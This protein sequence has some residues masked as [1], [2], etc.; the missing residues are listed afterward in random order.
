MS[1][2]RKHIIAALRWFALVCATLTTWVA[3]THAD[4]G[5]RVSNIA[6]ISQETANGTLVIST[7]DASF[8]I[9]A[10]RTPS[11]VEFFRVVDTAPDAISVRLNGS[12]FSPSGALSGPFSSFEDVVLLQQKPLNTSDPV[13]LVPAETYLPGE[14]MVVRVV[15]VGQNG[16]EDTIE[17]VVIRVTADNGDRLTLRLYEDTPNSGHFYGFFPSSPNQTA[18]N[19]RTLTAPQDALLTATYVDAFDASEVS[20]DTALVDPFGSVFD[21]YTGELIDNIRVS[22]VNADTGL[23]AEVLGIDG[24]GAYPAE[25]QTGESVTDTNRITYPAS[26]GTFFF[27]IVAPGRYRLSVDAPEGYVFPSSRSASEIQDL[28]SGP[29]ELRTDASFGDVFEV[30]STGPLN[31]DL[32]IDPAGDLTIRKRASDPQA[33]IG[34]FV[35]YTITLENT[36]TVPAPFALQDNLPTGLRYV[37]G[38]ARVNGQPFNDPQISGDGLG[39]LFEGGLVL[40]AST[41]QLT[42]LT[43]VGPGTPQ[44]EAVNRAIAVNRTG[45]AL[46][47]PTEATIYIEEDLLT[48]RMTI[49]G[50]VAEAACAPDDAWARS[51]LNGDGVPG[52][53][54][55]METGQYVVTDENGLYHFE[56]IEPGTHVVQVDEATLPP[57]YEPVICEENTRYAGSAL[58]KFVDAQGGSVW[59]ANFY[60]RQTDTVTKAETLDVAPGRDEAVYDAQWLDT[61]TS[62]DFDWVYPASDQPPQ[63]RSVELGILHGPQQRVQVQLNGTIVPGLNFSGRDLSSTRDVAISR[64]AGVDIQRGANRFVAILL[65]ETGNELNRIERVVWFVDEVDRAFHVDDQSRLIADGRNKPVIAVR[66]ESGDGHPVHEGRVVDIAVEEPYRLAQE[67]EEEFESP[68]DAGFSAVSGIRVGANGIAYVELEPTLDSG[69]A[70]VH[71]SLEDGS[72]QEIDVWLKPEKRDWIIVGLAEA[73]GMASKLENTEGRCVDELTSDG[74][75]AFFAKGVIKGDWLLTVALD[76]AKRHGAQDGE[77]FDRIDPNA[78]YT[79]YGDRTWQNNNAESRYPVYVKLE[80]NTFQAVFG[81]YETGFTETDLGRYSRRLSGLK[82]D[83]ESAALSVTAFAA[84][85]NQS[86]VKD[87]LAADGTSGPYRLSQA[88][89]VRSSEIITVETRNRVRPDEVVSLRPLSRYID[90]EIDYTT[91]ELFFR[92]PVAATD[93]ALNPNVIVIDY[94]TSDRGTRGVTAGLRAASRFADGAIQTGITVIH[95]DDGS[96]RDTTGSDLIGTDVTLKVGANTELRA[97]YAKSETQSERGRTSGDAVLIEAT[98]RTDRI[99][100]TGYY[101][102][103]SEGFGLGQQASSTSAIR[104]LG[105]QISAELGVI[106]KADSSDRIVR[107][108]EAQAYHETNLSQDAER[109]VG[110]IVWQQD[111]QT[112]GV[113]AGFRAVSENFG[114]TAAPRQSVLALAGLRKSFVDQ[115]LTISAVFEK[116]IKA[117]GNN[118]EEVTLFPERTV[119]GVDK[120]L[121]QRATANLRHEIT[122]GANASGQNTFAGITW[123]PL[124][125]TKISASTDMITNDSGRRIGATV[126]VDQVWQ[127]NQA[128]SVGAGLA[129]RTNVDGTDTPLDPTADVA[130]GPLEDG[131]RSP[132]TGAEQYRSGYLGAAYQSEDM[133]GSARLEA[134]ESTSGSRL[135]AVLGGAREITKSLSFSGA[136]RHQWENP[137]GQAV[138]EE[139]DIWLGAAWRPRGEGVIVLNR[140]DA[141][142][143]RQ[144]DDQN[145]T[146]IVNNLAVNAMVTKQTQVS[147]YHG[148]K[149]VETEFEGAQASGTT[150]LIGAEVRHDVYKGVDIGLQ[151]TWSSSDASRTETWS[152][153]P[154]VGFSPDKNVW[155]SL[156]W[157]VSGFGDADFE[158]AKYRNEGPYIKLRAKFDQNTAKGLLSSLGLGT[159]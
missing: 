86:F 88:P 132:L 53:R 1:F 60:L 70:R 28:A 110:D 81:D 63:G 59:R 151:T 99:S 22:I 117:R 39:L 44:G 10:K 46:S 115:G 145:R 143:A 27:P 41:I 108:I 54:L 100:A 76:T 95:E 82:A 138:R 25:V 8:I 136:A 12:D 139:T 131:I 92:Q 14:L 18:P 140:L 35:G 67:A 29:Y 116:P 65:D 13:N 137:T 75:L 9:E 64:W 69:R 68:V 105:A 40:P 55:Y 58:S 79:L 83:Y 30:T 155:V 133:A 78:Y 104:R 91:G 102:E 5:A 43:A 36:G 154:S 84:E 38:T 120:S 98:R 89:L 16:N 72:T 42:Y 157:N 49:V 15:D 61:Q 20:V 148:F 66:L 4:L 144:G 134:R 87:E 124:G 147:L 125:G 106:D 118:S 80:K 129:R 11:D 97:E 34:D 93:S 56:G 103:E 121:G 85:T 159:E 135:V 96:T 23:P 141:G 152:F 50:R 51:I 113:R 107:S 74:R 32:P 111:S 37:S 17:T 123:Q 101:R 3:A 153:G 114:E 57:G 128:W 127:I 90:Y 24:S 142:R 130:L 150:H 156:G 71:V 26:Q 146:K 94:E 158:A 33:A 45:A 52:V 73:E 119:L 47:N 31:I 19:D 122:N 62:S 109:N 7:N 48:S 112:L 6:N 2:G 126:G 149:H 21:S 77:I